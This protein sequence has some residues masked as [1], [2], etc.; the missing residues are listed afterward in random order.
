MQG[1]SIQL[2]E[3]CV[4]HGPADL[5]AKAAPVAMG[6][7]PWSGEELMLSREVVLARLATAGVPAAQ[8]RFLGAA[9]VAIVRDEM[10]MDSRELVEAALAHLESNLPAP[11]G[12]AYR[13]E[14]NAPQRA[15][16]PRA[17]NAGS[18]PAARRLSP[19][20]RRSNVAVSI[21]GKEL[22]VRTL[23][24]PPGLSAQ[25]GGGR[26]G[27]R[28]RRRPGARQHPHRDDAGRYAVLRG[29]ARP[30]GHG[31]G[32]RH[33]G[34]HGRPAEPDE[35]RPAVLL[36]RRNQTVVMRIQGDG[37]TITAVGQAM[38]DGR[39]GD[40]ILVQNVDSK[41]VVTAQVQEDGSVSPIRQGEKS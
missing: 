7:A 30:D 41:R 21:E 27:H 23:R 8:V 14:G 29:A 9:K 19:A 20:A 12:A 24:V 17:W 35:G 16:C 3:V 18:S 33:P 15:R 39:L 26:Q 22:A 25:A 11:R 2:G 37:F 36:V 6:R 34:R 4:L 10:L 38:Q 40:L 5:L 31:G 28:R 13:L 32:R 1:D